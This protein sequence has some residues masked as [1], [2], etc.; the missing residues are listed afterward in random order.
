MHPRVFAA[1]EDDVPEVRELLRVAFRGKDFRPDTAVAP[2]YIAYDTCDPLFRPEQYRFR[3]LRGRIVSA[4]KVFVR[5]L[6][7]PSGPIPI[8]L[9]GA[10]CTAEALRGRGLIGPVIAD[11]LDYSRR[12]GARAQFI[13]TPRRNYYLRHGYRYFP[14]VEYA[15]HL[16]EIPAFGARIE[17]L[18]YSDAGWMTE[19]FNAAPSGY[20]PIL[21]TEDYTRRWILGMRLAEPG[22]IGLKLL[23]RGRPCAYVLAWTQWGARRIIE[24]VS[25]SGRGRDEAALASALRRIGFAE[26]RAHFPDA[27]PLIAHL[28]ERRVRL[29]RSVEERFMVYPFDDALPMPDGHFLYSFADFV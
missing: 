25:R 27:H 13:V 26:F 6:R 29:T 11:S 22:A 17:P 21:R 3:R 8:T 1:T 7:H 28:R 12:I 19:V 5:T 18:Q 23:R 4:L 24:A 9:I 10:V 14:T 15:G 16:P 20:G 2:F